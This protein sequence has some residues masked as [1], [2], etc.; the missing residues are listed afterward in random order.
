[1]AVGREGKSEG[2]MGEVI[3][4]FS[5]FDFLCDS[6]ATRPAYI[7]LVGAG[8]LHGRLPR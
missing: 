2:V 6:A 4:N 8:L 5:D 1:M 7:L 3:S